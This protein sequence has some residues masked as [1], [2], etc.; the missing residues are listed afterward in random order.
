MNLSS[1]FCPLHKELHAQVLVTCDPASL[2]GWKETLAASIRLLNRTPHDGRSANRG[3]WIKETLKN[4]LIKS[5]FC[6]NS[7]GKSA[8]AA[9]LPSAYLTQ[10]DCENLSR[11]GQNPSLNFECE[12]V[13][14]IYS[15]QQNLSWQAI[16]LS[17]TRNSLHL[18]Q[19]KCY[20]HA[21]YVTATH[22]M[23]L[24]RTTFHCQAH[25]T[26]T[27]SML[28]PGTTFHCHAHV[29]AM[30]NMSLPR[31]TFHCHAHVTATH[32]MSLPRTTCHCHTPLRWA[33]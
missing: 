23:S 13:W 15:T 18:W 2:C 29:T 7:S 33:K 22:N 5:F 24:P 30:H 3:R 32:N 21:Q 6:T 4:W 12:T 19:P 31:T 27:H 25:V 10:I 17:W 1:S 9:L 14:S 8:S 20:C 28:L 11:L 16:N 26:A